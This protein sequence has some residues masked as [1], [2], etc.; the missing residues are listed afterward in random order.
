MRM[1]GK[2]V[3]VTGAGRGNGR[4]IAERLAAEGAAVVLGDINTADLEAVVSAITEAGGK[5]AGQY[6]DVSK[7]ADVEALMVAAEDL[8]GPHAVVAQAGASF[9]G[10]LEETSPEQ[11]DWFLSV[12][13]KGTYLCARAAI[14]RMRQLGGGS[15]VNMSGTYAYMPE[16]GVAVQAAAKGAIMAVTR[17]LAVEVGRDNIRANCIVP[18]YIETPMVTNWANM[19]ADPA[20]ARAAAAQLHA[21]RRMG[22]PEEVAAMALFLCSDDSS[23]STGHPYHVDGGLAT[24]MN[25]AKHTDES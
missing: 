21:L 3:V 8:G 16:Y 6:C 11:W 13:L 23:F 12:D 14:P 15:I 20:A 17:A 4:A 9:E 24:G 22:K 10:T 19:H 2:V 7:E 5:A 18:G 25:A 1:D